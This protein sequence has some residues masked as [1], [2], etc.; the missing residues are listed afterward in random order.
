M[1]KFLFFLLF[2][3]TTIFC[4]FYNVEPVQ[5]KHYE[6][7]SAGITSIFCI[8]QWNQAFVPNMFYAKVTKPDGTQTNWLEI[9]P[10]ERD[11]GWWFN[12]AGKYT[13]YTKCYGHYAM[14][15]YDN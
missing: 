12:M 14:D 10:L 6:L 4:Q 3:N 5:G 1:K 2:L 8:F 7:G 15:Y 13:I 11:K 9:R